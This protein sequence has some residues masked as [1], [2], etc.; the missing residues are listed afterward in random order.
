M[1]NQKKDNQKAATKTNQKKSATGEST[2]VDKP[3]QNKDEKT[4]VIIGFGK[5]N[6]S[7]IIHAISNKENSALCD[8]RVKDIAVNDDL[9]PKDCNCSRC[10]QY[11]A[12][13][14]LLTKVKENN[15][16]TKS[17][18][19]PPKEQQEIIKQSDEWETINHLIRLKFNRLE[20]RLKDF[21]VETIE[22][23]IASK[24]PFFIVK[25]TPEKYSIVHDPSRLT[26]C[27]GLS[28]EQAEKLLQE[29]LEIPYKWDGKS[30]MPIEWM[31]S[32]KDIF[33]KIQTAKQKKD[34]VKLARIIKRRKA[35]KKEEKKKQ[36]PKKRI[37]KRRSRH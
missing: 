9:S 33:Q 36:K 32:I 16:K 14:Q 15:K 19:V 2:N 20:K 35:I 4:K 30:K 17:K 26:V 3:K 7:N 8:I 6:N 28:L 21:I 11:L 13:K 10:Q 22:E 37:I 24:P 5:K 18:T 34:K 23:V 1:A 27:S 12:F 31:S 25:I 29:Y